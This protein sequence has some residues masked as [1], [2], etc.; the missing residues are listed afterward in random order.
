MGSLV[1]LP[2][3]LSLI[4]LCSWPV[5]YFESAQTKQSLGARIPKNQHE[6]KG[7]LSACL[8][9]W[10]WKSA[11]CLGGQSHGR[12]VNITLHRQRPRTTEEKEAQK[13]VEATLGLVWGEQSTL[14]VCLLLLV[15]ANV[16]ECLLTWCWYILRVRCGS[17]DWILPNSVFH[18]FITIVVILS[19]LVEK[20][21]CQIKDSTEYQY[22]SE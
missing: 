1:V 14:A 4:Y 11:E 13:R 2:S 18:N 22:G 10:V 17:S 8:T 7:E 16:C 15:T 12:G 6:G 9:Q 19:V 21:F 3:A 5:Q 20:S